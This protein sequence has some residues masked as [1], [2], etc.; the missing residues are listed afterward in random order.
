[1]TGIGEYAFG[2]CQ[3]LTSVN[4]PNSVT[5]IGP[6]AFTQCYELTSV[7]I[8]NSVTT[9]GY[10]AFS[11]CPELATVVIGNGIT[12]VEKGAFYGCSHMTD[13]YCYAEKVPELGDEVFEFWINSATLHVPE[14]SLEAYS[15]AEQWKDFK[16]IVALTGDDPKPT[17]IMSANRDVMTVERY[18][19]IDGKHTITPQRGLNIIRMSDG[20]TKKIVIK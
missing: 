13:M 2:D 5:N 14:S 18:Y 16:E 17:G 1:M 7:T 19:T 20:T 6:S 9:I 8:P 10:Y 3:G 15:N 4:I 12:N 11:G